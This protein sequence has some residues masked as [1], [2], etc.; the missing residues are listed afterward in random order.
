MHYA[1]PQLA[2]SRTALQPSGRRLFEVIRTLLGAC[3]DRR[4]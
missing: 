3:L 1:S 4:F 2:L